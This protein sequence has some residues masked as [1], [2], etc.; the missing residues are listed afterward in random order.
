MLGPLSDRL[1]PG[2]SDDPGAPLALCVSV[3]ALPLLG[4]KPHPNHY[5]HAAALTLALTLTIM[6][7]PPPQP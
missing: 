3:A 1:W 5:D 2:G 7:I 6:I 4:L